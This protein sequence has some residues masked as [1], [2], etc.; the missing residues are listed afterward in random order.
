MILTLS[1]KQTDDMICYWSL[2]HSY[3]YFFNSSQAMY[4]YGDEYENGNECQF[5]IGNVQHIMRQIERLRQKIKCQFLIGNVQ[6]QYLSTV[7][8]ILLPIFLKINHF[9]PKK[10]VDLFYIRTATTRMFTGFADIFLFSE[11]LVLRSTY[12]LSHYELFLLNKTPFFAFPHA[13]SP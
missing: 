10:Y 4:N 12:F 2:G 1:G 7:F 9:L 5:L 8:F 13:C 3:I 6:Q 11:N